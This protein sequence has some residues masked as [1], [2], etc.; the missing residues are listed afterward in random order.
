MDQIPIYLYFT[1][2]YIFQLSH[3]LKLIKEFLHLVIS[4]LQVVRTVIGIK[5]TI[6]NFMLWFHYLCQMSYINHELWYSQACVNMHPNKDHEVFTDICNSRLNFHK[7]LRIQARTQL[8]ERMT[9]A[10]VL[11]ESKVSVSLTFHTFVHYRQLALIC[12]AKTRAQRRWWHQSN[13]LLSQQKGS[14][15]TSLWQLPESNHIT[16]W[17]AEG[18]LSLYSSPAFRG[19]DWSE[20]TKSASKPAKLLSW[21]K[22]LLSSAVQCLLPFP[23]GGSVFNWVTISL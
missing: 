14:G 4:H 9:G 21:Q 16:A 6:K 5:I 3:H 23:E 22:Q 12:S 19:K 8:C 1:C 18:S 11:S 13:P 7:H 15:G 2:K 10:L 20:C 17:M